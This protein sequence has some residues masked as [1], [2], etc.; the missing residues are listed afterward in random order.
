MIRIILLST[1]VFMLFYC[2]SCSQYHMEGE[3]QVDRTEIK[4][5]DTLILRGFSTDTLYESRHVN[6]DVT[7]YDEQGAFIR[8]YLEKTDTCEY[9][10][11]FVPDQ[12]GE[13]TIDLLLYYKSTSAQ[14]GASVVIS[15]TE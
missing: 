14:P 2:G 1:L 9:T 3:I 13:Y 6:W 7:A 8:A 11:V 4:V 12:P 5:N 10:A 15:V